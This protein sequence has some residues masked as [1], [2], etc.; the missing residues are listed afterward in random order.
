MVRTSITRL[1]YLLARRSASGRILRHG[2]GR[3]LRAH[4]NV[5]DAATYDEYGF[6][7]NLS[8]QQVLLAS[9]QA[10]TYYIMLQGD[11]A[12]AGGQPFTL[13]AQ[14]LT[15]GVLGVSPS[16]GGNI[17]ETTVTIQ[18]A[19]LSPSTAVSLVGSN[20]TRYPAAATF[21]QNSTTLYATFDLTGLSLG[22][23]DVRVDDKGQTDTDAGAFSVI[24]GGGGDVVYNMSASQF[25][26]RRH[27]G[28][29]DRHL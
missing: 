27:D 12:S 15:F 25:R 22:P 21:F 8:T 3:A 16:R 1:I 28:Y 7:L 20:G 14:E 17:G 6:N 18:G 2:G 9:P 11:Q 19:D 29:R 24:A 4:Q 5:P 10:G 26:P 13:T 23:Y